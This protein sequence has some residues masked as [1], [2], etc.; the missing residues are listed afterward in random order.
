MGLL[1]GI[2]CAATQVHFASRRDQPIGDRQKKRRTDSKQAEFYLVEG[3][4]FATL[5]ASSSIY[6]DFARHRSPHS[7]LVAFW[8]HDT[9]V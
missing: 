9:K 2:T 7:R 6:R 5:P 4:R 8:R 3:D 1:A